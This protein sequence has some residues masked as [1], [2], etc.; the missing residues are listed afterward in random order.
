VIQEL[1]FSANVNRA[2]AIDPYVGYAFAYFTG[3]SVAGEKIYLAASNGT[4]YFA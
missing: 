3:D 4:Y 2:A 1:T